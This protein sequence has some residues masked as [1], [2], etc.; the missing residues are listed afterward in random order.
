M[1]G[2]IASQVRT[3]WSWMR[4]A[5]YLAPRMTWWLS[6]RKPLVSLSAC[7]IVAGIAYNSDSYVLVPMLSSW[8]PV[9]IFQGHYTNGLRTI[10]H[11]DNF[12][13]IHDPLN[14]ETQATWGIPHG[15]KHMLLIIAI[16][17]IRSMTIVHVRAPP[18]LDMKLLT[19]LEGRLSKFEE[20]LKKYASY[21]LT[22]R[23]REAETEP[24][25]EG[26]PLPLSVSRSKLH[27]IHVIDLQAE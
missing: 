13:D 20:R 1:S 3:S 17:A 19:D 24:S 7:L 11:W 6:S 22:L 27:C 9:E 14:W 21:M 18:A 10:T 16:S 26:T 12:V 8:I 23:D 15:Y 4:S 5:S 25:E 2:P